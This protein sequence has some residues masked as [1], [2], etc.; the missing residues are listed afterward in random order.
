M[1]ITTNFI[2]QTKRHLSASGSILLP[3]ALKWRLI[4]VAL[5]ALA[6]SALPTITPSSVH[7]ASL[8]ISIPQNPLTVSVS[9]NSNGGFSTASGTL[10]V[11]GDAAWGYTLTVKSGKNSLSSE[12]GNELKTIE[13]ATSQVDFPVNH[14]GYMPNKLNSE[15]NTQYLP[16]PT[17]AETTI[18]KTNT[19]TDTTGTTYGF[20]LAAKV[21]ATQPAGL[22][23]GTFAFTATANIV[24]YDIK[25]ECNDGVGCSSQVDNTTEK[26]VNLDKAPTKVGYNFK[27]W[28]SVETRDAN[29]SSVKYDASS[30]YTLQNGDNDVTLYAMWELFKP[31]TMQN[32]NPVYCAQM[33]EHETIE[34]EDVRDGNKYDVRKLKDNQCWMVENL[35]ISDK[36]LTEEDS[37]V[38]EPFTL[39]KSSINGFNSATAVNVYVESDYY[40]GFYTWFTATAGEGKNNVSENVNYSICPKGWRLPTGGTGGEFEKL[41]NLY[42]DTG[43]TAAEALLSSKGPNFILAGCYLNN[44][45]ANRGG[46]YWSST[47]IDGSTY[48]LGLNDSAVFPLYSLVNSGFG[49][50]V[51]CVV[52][53]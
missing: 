39:P 46:W 13:K 10:K 9:A 49:D 12:E 4:T 47:I 15:N 26:T 33:K 34:L 43:A 24:K 2:K 48:R 8:T 42:G 27:G 45:L 3:L 31:T 28:C 40:G 25:Y 37:D 11:S 21:D 7:A 29:C 19:A 36:T 38:S 52:R 5:C 50:S 1:K 16:G 20:T 30:P 44:A 17:S 23:S 18:D 53:E 14:W 6:V 32:F 41:A 35:R 22:Y 51:R